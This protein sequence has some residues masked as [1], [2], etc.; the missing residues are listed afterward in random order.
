[1]ALARRLVRWGVT[2]CVLLYAVTIVVVNYG[3]DG[4][5]DAEQRT[6][7]FG[8]PSARGVTIDSSTRSQRG[9]T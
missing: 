6:Q 3:E 9:R 8:P 5:D 7:P 4:G 2:A 1:M